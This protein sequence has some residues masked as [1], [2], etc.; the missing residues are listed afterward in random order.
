MLVENRDKIQAVQRM[1][2]YI[3][4]H[5]DTE[6]DMDKLAAASGYSRFHASR[7]FKQ[8]IGQTPS[9]YIRAVRLSHAAENLRDTGERVLD[10]ALNASFESHDGLPVRFQS[11]S[12]SGLPPIRERPRRS[13]C[14]PITL[15]PMHFF[16]TRK[17]MITK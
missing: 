8:Y 5:A 16:T 14:L 1:Q 2:E 12:G 13:A 6:I 10:T 4:G 11:S 3:I 15:L 17:G 7:L 9:D